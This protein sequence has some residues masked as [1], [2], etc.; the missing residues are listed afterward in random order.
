MGS[1]VPESSL[2]KDRVFVTGCDKKPIQPSG[3]DLECQVELRF[4]KTLMTKGGTSQIHLQ[5]EVE[6][7]QNTRTSSLLYHGKDWG[8]DG[9]ALDKEQVAEVCLAALSK[10]QAQCR[11]TQGHPTVVPDDWR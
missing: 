7:K 5:Q 6:G 8:T 9:E 11:V 1:A 3:L 4:L 2:V 10:S